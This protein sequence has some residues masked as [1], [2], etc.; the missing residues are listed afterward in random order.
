[1]PFACAS[2]CC[3]R[4]AF[5]NT[6]PS[7]PFACASACCKRRAFKNT[8][9]SMPFAG[10]S[11]CCKRRAFKNTYPSMPFACASGLLQAKAFQAYPS[12]PFAGVQAVQAKGVQKY[13]SFNALRWRFRLVASEGR[14]KIHILQCPSLA[15]Q[16]CCKRRAFKN[17]YPSMPFAGASGLLQ[18][19]GVQKYISFNALRWSLSGLLQA[20]GVQKYISFN[21]LRCAS[22]L[23]QAKG[24]QK[25]ISFNALRWR[26]RL[27]ASEGRSKIHILQCPSLALQACCKRRAFK[28]TYPSMPFAGASGLLQAKGVQKYISFNALRWRFRLVASEGRSKIHILQCPSLAL[29]AC[30]KRRAF[31]NTYPSMPFAGASGLLQAKGVQ[32]YI[33]FNALRWR[34]RLVASEEN[35]YCSMPFAGASGLWQAT[36]PT[37]LAFSTAIDLALWN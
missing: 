16:A 37:S 14:S 35:A 27:V 19:K 17:T 33:S 1:M 31:K 32:K 7:M 2:A 23:L 20:K 26:F 18:A 12:M 15:L 13:I 24:V 28:N 36:F 5:K 22:G 8:Y 4:R 29:Q 25:Y 34:F 10:A 30:C 21:A 9:P 11:A 3:K 6:Y